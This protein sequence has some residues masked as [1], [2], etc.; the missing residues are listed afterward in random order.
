MPTNPSG[1]KVGCNEPKRKHQRM[2]ADLAGAHRSWARDA[3]ATRVARGARVRV[4]IERV[5]E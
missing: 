2:A 3:S 5:R 4:S 1:Q